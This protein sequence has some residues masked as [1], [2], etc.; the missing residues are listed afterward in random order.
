MEEKVEDLGKRVGELEKACERAVGV[1]E[2]WGGRAESM[3]KRLGKAEEGGVVVEDTH[4]RL[5]KVEE[6]YVVVSRLC[7]ELMDRV[8]RPDQNAREKE[9]FDR[10]V[11]KRLHDLE[12][13]KKEERS[14]RFIRLTRWKG[15]LRKQ[16]EYARKL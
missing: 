15:R 5:E 11:N 8:E 13:A 1:C 14:R 6:V 16:G 3:D 10:V 7:E 2:D 9:S 12:V 4:E